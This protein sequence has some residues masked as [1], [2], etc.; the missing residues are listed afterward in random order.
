MEFFKSSEQIVKLIP[1]YQLREEYKYI[2]I[3]ILYLYYTL[4][5]LLFIFIIIYIYLECVNIN[6]GVAEIF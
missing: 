2:N 1:F 6:N 5:V 4:Y 3:S